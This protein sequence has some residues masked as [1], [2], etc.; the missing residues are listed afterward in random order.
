M[1]TVDRV[2]E[3]SGGRNVDLSY[4]QFSKNPWQ[5]VQRLYP[6]LFFSVYTYLGDLLGFPR[7]Y[8]YY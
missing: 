8:Y 2:V 1:W 7:P 6:Q 5:L 3:G 4:P